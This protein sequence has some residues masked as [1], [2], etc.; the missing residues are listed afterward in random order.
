MKREVSY[1]RRLREVVAAHDM[2]TVT[3]LVPLLRDRDGRLHPPGVRQGGDG[4]GH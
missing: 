2:F 3:E 4:F 1:Q